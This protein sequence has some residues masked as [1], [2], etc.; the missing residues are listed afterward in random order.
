MSGPATD[1]KK[2]TDGV[3]LPVQYRSLDIVRERM[4]D[5]SKRTLELSFSSEEPVERWFGKEVLDHGRGVDLSR[6]NNKAAL[7][8]DHDLTKQIGVVEKAWLDGKVGRAI[9]RFSKSEDGERE[10]RE[11]IDGI[12]TKIS[13][14]YRIL[15]AVLEETGK[16]TQDTYRVTDWMPYEISTVSVPADDTVGIGRSAPETEHPVKIEGVAARSPE[17]TPAPDD[18]NTSRPTPSEPSPTENQRTMTT[19]APAAPAAPTTPAPTVDRA[20]ILKE[21]R[22]RQREFRAIGERFGLKPDDVQRALDSDLS[23]DGFRAQV[24]NDFDPTTKPAPK[25]DMRLGMPERERGQFSILKAIRDINNGGLQGLEKEVFDECVKRNPDLARTEKQVLVPL[26]VLE[27]GRRDLEVG[28][29]AEGGYTVQTN[30]GSM[31]ELLRNNQV[32]AAMGAQ[33]ITGLRGNLSLPKHAGGA[34]ASWVD[35]EGSVSDS[36]QSFGQLALTPKRLASRTAFSLQLVNQSSVSIENFVRAD[37]MRVVAIELDRAAIAGSGS[38]NQ[39]TGIIST[40]SV[41][42]IT[43]GAAPTWA[44]VVSF[45]TETAV[46]NALMGSLGFLTTPGVKGAWKTTLKDSGVSGYLWEGEAVNGYKAMATNQVPSNKV[47][48]GNWAELLVATWGVMS[49]V[50]D[51]YSKAATGQLVITINSFHDIGVRH[52]TSFAVSSDAGNQ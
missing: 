13:F 9:V 2:L 36:A 37:L 15:R 27:H 44:K 22:E 16:G 10:M 40:G 41:N 33:Q 31:I 51:P 7:L 39:P 32:T 20:A 3:K 38:S 17:Q 12:R 19:E 43:F 24:M 6:L 50:V 14:G 1:E 42:S 8:R 47:I 45:E 26:D 4:L 5:E 48:F 29:A 21:E 18:P 35:E 30:L 34:T 25:A 52:P 46:D 28:T 23:L 11:I 49:I